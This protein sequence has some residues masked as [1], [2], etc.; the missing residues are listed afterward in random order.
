MIELHLNSSI[1]K[2][3]IKSCLKAGSNECGGILFGHHIAENTFQI[4]EITADPRQGGKFAFFVRNLKW[5]LKR[6]N[7]FFYKYKNEY[8]KFNYLGEW[9]SH[10]QF[11]LMPSYQDNKTMEDL[12]NDSS[13][14]AN[15]LVLMI[16]KLE[17][18][19]LKAK[20][21]VY[22]P[23]KKRHDCQIIFN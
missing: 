5:S 21:W 6:L 13:V 17:N 1:G 20:A 19:E 15:F 9:H 10:P 12:I 16:I 23:N 4:K 22:F 8:Q 7:H 3:M 14:G 2:K 18:E 11:A